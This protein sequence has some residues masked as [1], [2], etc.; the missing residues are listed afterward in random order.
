MTDKNVTIA[1]I[2][3]QIGTARTFMVQIQEDPVNLKNQG[4][5]AIDINWTLDPASANQ[6]WSFVV[7][8]VKGGIDVKDKKKRFSDKKHSKGDHTWTRNKNQ[9][10]TTGPDPVKYSIA[11]TRPDAVL[12]AT[13][14]IIDPSINNEE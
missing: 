12:G 11:L 5:G 6:G 2:E 8:A 1:I 9:A 4:Q 10:S 7:D 3:T 13:T 14:L